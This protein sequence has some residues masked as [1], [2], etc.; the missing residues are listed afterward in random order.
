MEELSIAEEVHLCSAPVTLEYCQLDLITAV[1]SQ[2]K[3][4]NLIC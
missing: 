4:L 2:F 1:V 3:N